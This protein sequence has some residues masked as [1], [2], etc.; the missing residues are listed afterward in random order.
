M[1]NVARLAVGFIGFISGSAA[2]L[3]ALNYARERLQG[4]DLESIM[5]PDAPP[6]SYYPA[7]G[8]ASNAAGDEVTCRGDAQFHLL[9][10][11]LDR[12]AG[13]LG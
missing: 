9:Y 11:F 5:D 4:K 10:Q 13:L 6:G 12:L 7:S 3:Y 2:Y 1:M 8:R